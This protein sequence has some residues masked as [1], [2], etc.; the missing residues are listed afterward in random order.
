VLA[1]GQPVDLVG[2]PVDPL[3][4]PTDDLPELQPATTLV[5]GRTTDVSAAWDGVLDGSTSSV[6]SP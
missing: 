1:P 4:C 5:G 3:E 6:G 2:Y